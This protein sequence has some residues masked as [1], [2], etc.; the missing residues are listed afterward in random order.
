[1]FLMPIQI[2]V[3]AFVYSKRLTKSGMILASVYG[4]STQIEQDY[5]WTEWILKPL[6]TCM[7]CVAGQMALCGLILYGWLN[8]E[9]VRTVIDGLFFLSFTILL[10]EVINKILHD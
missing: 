2:S 3:I 5:P 4:K 7:Y 1:M 8:I 6:M 10:V 9:M